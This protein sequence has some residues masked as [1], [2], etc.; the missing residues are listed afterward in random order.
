MSQL[1][2]TKVARRYASALFNAARKLGSTDV[3]QRDL[4]TL[5]M[6][7]N[8]TPALEKA[9]ESP[10]IPSERKQAILE[11]LFSGEF[12]TLTRS[13]L[14]LLVEKQR[15]NLLRIVQEEYR[16]QA[17]DAH[18]LIRAQATVALPL[19]DA[20]KQSIVAGLQQRT[21]KQIELSVNV[22]PGILGGVVV[23]MHDT[24][25][26]GSVRG[27]LERLREKMLLER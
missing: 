21:G 25:I 17:D 5:V 2:D 9:M 4:D 23:R 13:F 7:W 1:G 6:L 3:V 26:D 20:Q 15:E 16:R 18:G 22:D 10:L 8:Q 27:S 19:D 14:R 11:E 24:V 12:D